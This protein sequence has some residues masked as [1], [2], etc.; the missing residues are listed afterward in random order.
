MF[1]EEKPESQ[2]LA[3]KKANRWEVLTQF[4]FGLRYE[5]QLDLQL[6]TDRLVVI[7]SN[8]CQQECKEGLFSSGALG[9]FLKLN[10]DFMGK[11]EVG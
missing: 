2:K 10:L 1:D 5:A 3:E 7:L 11:L 6:P 8:R 4:G 9:M